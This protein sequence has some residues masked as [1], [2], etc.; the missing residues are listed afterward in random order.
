MT[1]N[2]FT[3]IELLVVIAIIG[4]LTSML[5]PS[6][7][8]ARE[9]TRASLCMSN[10]RQIAVATFAV[11]DSFNEKVGP[12]GNCQQYQASESKGSL[13]IDDQALGWIGNALLMI[14]ATTSSSL[15]AHE[16]AVQDLNR[17]KRYMCPND[18]NDVPTIDVNFSGAGDPPNIITSYAPNHNVFQIH[19]NNDHILG[20]NFA[21]ISK[22]AESLM[23]MDSENIDAWNT[24]YIFA[25][26][27]QTMLQRYND[28]LGGNWGKIF[29]VGRHINDKMPLVL[30]DGHSEIVRINSSGQMGKIGITS[31]F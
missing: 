19:N 2:K 30:F 17:M 15:A 1:E 4:I 27:D 31:G 8:N 28:T 6:L 25:G 5:L 23:V 20:G 10:V 3:L 13:K 14:D 29:P 26:R 16:D 24:R 12:S 22:P 18:T 9:T 21:A 11:S 7:Q